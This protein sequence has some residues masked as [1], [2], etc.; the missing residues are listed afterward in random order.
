LKVINIVGA[1]PNFMK[2]APIIE[3]MNKHP[4]R[5]EHILVHTGQH[6]DE[7]M[8]VSF[9]G[10]LGMPQPDINLEVGSGS[11]AEQTARI[12]VA[13][14]KICLKEKPDLVIVVGD[15]NST[16]ACT[17][18]AKKL[19]IKVAHVAVRATGRSQEGGVVEQAGGRPL[20]VLGD[21]P[22]DVGDAFSVPIVEAA[23]QV[24]DTE[25]VGAHED[26]RVVL[27]HGQPRNLKGTT[28]DDLC[29]RRAP[30]QH[31]A[32][33]D[34]SRQVSR[35]LIVLAALFSPGEVPEVASTMQDPP[36]IMRDERCPERGGNIF[37]VLSH[38]VVPIDVA[39][40]CLSSPSIR[41]RT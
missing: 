4:E 25:S 12:M 21:H 19:G 39:R 31:L 18:T 40:H 11:H 34:E 26:E 20:H 37:T 38:P 17:I 1:R 2:M 22:H 7:K 16:M 5:I 30:R 36:I 32:V 6:Y 24:T 15:V 41:R 8:S 29:C 14:E 33:V 27:A 10:D 28:I 3:A 35:K 9:F 23:R 13:F